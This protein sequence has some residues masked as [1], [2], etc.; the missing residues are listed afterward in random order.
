MTA[1]EDQP[2]LSAGKIED[3]SEESSSSSSEESGDDKVDQE[4]SGDDKV[5]EEEG[6]A[7]DEEEEEEDGDALAEDNVEDVTMGGAGEERL[8]TPDDGQPAA[9]TDQDHENKRRSFVAGQLALY[10]GR[11]N[12]AVWEEGN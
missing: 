10:V 9:I 5:G 11:Y 8:P 1:P 6:G 2:A 12:P 4:G 3:A 7:R